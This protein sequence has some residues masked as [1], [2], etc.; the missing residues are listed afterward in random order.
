MPQV[1]AGRGDFPLGGAVRLTDLAGPGLH[2]VLARLREA[3]PVA[4]L[5]ALDGWLVTG[6]DL[7]VGC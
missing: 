2:Q 7:A 4:W 5:P 6:Y 1:A 3:E